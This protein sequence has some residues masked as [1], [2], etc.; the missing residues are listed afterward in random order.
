MIYKEWDHGVI[1]GN[2]NYKQTKKLRKT[3]RP[4]FN[5]DSRSRKNTITMFKECN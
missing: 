2:K 3:H 5:V 1:L 4:G